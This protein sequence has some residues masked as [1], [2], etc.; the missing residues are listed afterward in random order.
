MNPLP[1]LFVLTPLGEVQTVLEKRIDPPTPRGYPADEKPKKISLKD[2]KVGMVGRKSYEAKKAESLHKNIQAMIGKHGV[3]RVV[4][5]TLTFANDP[6]DL[7]TAQK[8]FNSIAKH[9]LHDLF[10]SYITAVHRGTERG[11]I[12]Y[13]LIAVTREDVRTGFDFEAW[14]ALL[15]HVCLFGRHNARY[16]DLCGPVFSSANPALKSIWKAFRDRAATYGFGMVET[17]PIRSNAEAIGRYVGSYV[18]VAAVNR[19]FRDKRMRTLRYAMGAGQRVASQRFSWVEGAG[20]AWRAGCR[21]LG[22]LLGVDDF[23][24]HFGKRWAWD[25]RENIALLGRYSERMSA[26]FYE[27]AQSLSSLSLG[28]RYAQAGEFCRQLAAFEKTELARV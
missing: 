24:P 17:Y 25:L 20:A 15:A 10:L 19:Q 4:L 9:L 2:C 7:R 11:R 23:A 12:H 26:K 16:R 3:E 22:L 27:V 28:E 13:H 14:N 18:R 21:M 1:C 5:C 6:K 8:R